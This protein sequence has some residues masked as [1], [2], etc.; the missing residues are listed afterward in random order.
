[1]NRCYTHRWARFYRTLGL[2]RGPMVLRGPCG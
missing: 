2:L 1:M